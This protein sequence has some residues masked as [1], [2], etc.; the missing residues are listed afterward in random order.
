M[1]KHFADFDIWRHEWF[2]AMPPAD[3]LAWFYITQ[4]CS[5][6]GI[7]EIQLRKYEYDVGQPLHVKEFL[8]HVNGEAELVQGEL[9]HHNKRVE[10]LPGGRHLWVVKYC[11]FHYPVTRDCPQGLSVNQRAHN[12]VFIELRKWKLLDRVMAM[13]KAAGATATEDVSLAPD[14]QE[15]AKKV[16]EYLNERTGA[17]FRPTDSILRPICGRLGEGYTLADCQKVIDY[18]AE[19]WLKDKDMA[20]YLR[21][22]TLFSAQKFAGYLAAAS[23]A[24]HASADPDRHKKGFFHDTKQGETTK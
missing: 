14:I 13:Y 1:A 23:R 24:Q 15:Q 22:L 19:E 2:A 10:L 11:L 6:A 8:A 21:P 12:N 9:I 17:K 7:W 4:N 20:Q 16:V 3:K 18:K 5:L